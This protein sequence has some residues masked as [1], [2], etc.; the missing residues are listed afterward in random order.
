MWSVQR[1]ARYHARR[2][3]FFDTWRKATSFV[4]VLF[5]S[6]AAVDLLNKG[7]LIVALIASFVVAT[8]SAF[9]LVVG[10]ADMARKHDDLRRRFV[11][12]ESTI[13]PEEESTDADVN[14]WCRERL[15]IEIDE[16]PIYVAVDLLCENELAMSKGDQPRVVISFWRRLLAN[17][18]RQEDLSP[19][20]IPPV[21]PPAA[22]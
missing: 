11:A 17:W 4:S 5:A 22:A 14:A 10:T 12:L 1:S 20:R 7:D 18:W 13:K 16:P 15:A 3:G 6:A 8:M 9:D 2:Q 21:T 19:K